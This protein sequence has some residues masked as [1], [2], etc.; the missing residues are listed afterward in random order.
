ML[1]QRSRP[2][3][4]LDFGSQ[5]TQLI[6]RRVREHGVYCEIDPLGT[7]PAAEVAR[8]EA[9]GRHPLRRAGERLRAGAPR[10]PTRGLRARACRS[11]ASATACSCCAPRAR[12]RGRRRPRE[13]EYGRARRSLARRADRRCSPACP[14]TPSRG[15]DEPRRPRA[16]AARPG[17]V[18]A[19]RDA[20]TRPFAG[21]APTGAADLRPPVPPRGRA[22]RARPRDPAQ[23]PV[24]RSAA[25]RP[26][27]RWRSFVERGGRARSA[28][29]VGRRPRRLRPLG[30]RRFVG[31][32]RCSCT[33]RS[34]TR[35]TCIFVDNGLLRAGR[36]APRSSA[37]SASTSACA[38]IVRRRARAASSSASPASTDPEQKRKIIGHDVHRGLRGGG[39]SDSAASSSW[40]RARST[41]T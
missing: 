2:I 1:R 4:I 17:F 21:G 40:R 41:P 39:A 3:L 25:A 32:R 33:A 10:L 5:Y 29:Q 7:P 31:R 27:G 22:H 15:L 9:E 8:L 35:L 26:T 16:A 13:R 28:Q 24:P 14:A 38:S 19:R 37:C 20:T 34:A 30:R 36:G 6:A 23:L 11:S 12:R 18:T